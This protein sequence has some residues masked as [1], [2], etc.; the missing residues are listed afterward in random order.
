MALPAS[1]L[2]EPAEYERVTWGTALPPQPDQ[3]VMYV[4]G[5]PIPMEADF[6]NCD[7]CNAAIGPGDPCCAWSIWVDGQ[8][9]PPPWEN[10]FMIPGERGE[11]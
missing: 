6:Y 9:M 10:E 1:A 4:N 7:L 2:G 5:E 8:A 3:R 11:T